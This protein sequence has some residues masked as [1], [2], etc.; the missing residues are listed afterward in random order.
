MLSTLA[1]LL[2]FASASLHAV[3]AQHCAYVEAK[4]FAY[5]IFCDY[6]DE[7]CEDGRPFQEDIDMKENELP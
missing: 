4:C 2:M 5:M 6:W 1:A 3:P 7:H